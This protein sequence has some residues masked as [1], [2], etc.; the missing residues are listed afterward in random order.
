MTGVCFRADGLPRLRFPLAPTKD[1]NRRPSDL[2]NRPQCMK[3]DT[4][5]RLKYIL[6]IGYLFSHQ[7][8][9]INPLPAKLPIITKL[10]TVPTIVSGFSLVHQVVSVVFL[11]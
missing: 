6:H 11:T 4:K 1:P 3:L 10:T 2:L 8:V 7:Y 9:T 5:W